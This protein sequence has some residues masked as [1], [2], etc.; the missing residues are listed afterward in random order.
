MRNTI[1]IPKNHT[2]LAGS[3]VCENLIVNGELTITGELMARRVTG[4]G[5]VD[6]G[7]ITAETVRCEN[8]RADALNARRLCSKNVTAGVMRLG[9]DFKAV[10]VKSAESFEY[11][12]EYERR[13]AYSEAESA[14]SFEYAQ[15][16][17][18]R[19]AYSEAESA[20]SGAEFFDIDTE[21]LNA[22][23]GEP[24]KESSEP[25]ADSEAR[26]INYDRLLDDPAF[27]RLRALY[28]ME[29]EYGGTWRLE[30]NPVPPEDIFP[31]ATAA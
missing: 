27:L 24:D 19:Q 20:E 9:N 4:R 16:Y 1:R 13:Q 28:A 7:T 2:W 17:E 10:Y 6:A 8:V 15:E 23:G 22:S 26:V 31:A 30:P 11:A 21:E 25:D 18:H 14:G 29:R 3:L 5:T 12:P